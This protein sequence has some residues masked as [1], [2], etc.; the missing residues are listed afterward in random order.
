MA[1]AVF[2]LSFRSRQIRRVL[3]ALSAQSEYP[4]QYFR[5]RYWMSNTTVITRQ[6]QC[7]FFRNVLNTLHFNAGENSIYSPPSLGAPSEHIGRDT[8]VPS[9]PRAFTTGNRLRRRCAPDARPGRPPNE[10]T[11]VLRP[12]LIMFAND[13][14][15]KI[16]RKCTNTQTSKSRVEKSQQVWSH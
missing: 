13:W 8:G 5:G 10:V 6:R 11:G 7:Y 9:V 16:I 4:S 3:S 14:R 2:L 12:R 1:W 15:F